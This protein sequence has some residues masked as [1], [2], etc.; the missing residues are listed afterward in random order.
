VKS[1]KFV[2]VLIGLFLLP[3]ILC[4]QSVSDYL[5][6]Q[7]IGSYKFS[8]QSVNP[9]TDEVKQ[10][11]GY[12]ILKNPGVLTGTD[13][14]RIDHKDTTY[15]TDYESD[16]TDIGVEV[17]VTQHTGGDSDRWLLHE[18]EDSYRDGDEHAKLGLL[19]QATRLREI[20][21]NKII[22]RRGNGY[23]W[24]SNNF[25]IDV[26]YTDL[27]GN[28]PEPLEIVQAYLAKFPSSITITD[29]TFKSNAY[30]VKW[31]KDEM[32][33]RLWLCDKWNAQYQSGGV[34]QANL[35]VKLL[36]NMD[37]F[38]KYREKY[39]KIAAE[40]ESNLLDTYHENND[41]VSIQNKLKEYKTWWSANKG[42]AITLP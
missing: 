22:G 4:A 5:I 2:T 20:N 42:K 11:P 15:E 41:L 13:H 9:I 21:G 36:E 38:L 35:M 23:T 26:S 34:T 6:L 17:Q 3:I 24:V 33:R 10:I 40:D 32:D 27:K 7:N 18:I 29:A 39:F 31:I 30:N 28:K 25:V 12:T 14:F 1:I 16:V 19:I 37:I 8:T